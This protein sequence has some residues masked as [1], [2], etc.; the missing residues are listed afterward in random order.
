M[1]VPKRKTS[2]SKKRM[3]RSHQKL[4][5]V[6]TGSISSLLSYTK[7]KDTATKL[8]ANLADVTK[9]INGHL[10]TAGWGIDVIDGSIKGSVSIHVASCFLNL[11]VDFPLTSLVSAFEEHVLQY[12]RKSGTHPIAFVNTSSLAP[13]LGRNHGCAVIF[14]KDDGQSVGKS[15][16]LSPGGVL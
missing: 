9:D 1:A 16:N 2:V 15:A 6:N 8:A 14:Q 12:V 5:S 11:L 4:S 10:G 7:I 13:G 3:R